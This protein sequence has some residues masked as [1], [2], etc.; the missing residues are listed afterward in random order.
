MSTEYRLVHNGRLIKAFPT[1][2]QA[3]TEAFERHFIVFGGG[4]KY[5]I[6]GVTIEEHNL[7]TLFKSVRTA[8]TD[9]NNERSREY[10]MLYYNNA[11]N[12]V[13]VANCSNHGVIVWIGEE[14]QPARPNSL[15]LGD[16]HYFTKSSHP[17]LYKGSEWEI[18]DGTLTLTQS[19]YNEKH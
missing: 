5:L 19:K 14:H 11:H 1:K 4:H 17:V 12:I 8:N 2:I 9:Q 18:F 7:T 10:G 6:D 13:V 3:I 16:T 15:I